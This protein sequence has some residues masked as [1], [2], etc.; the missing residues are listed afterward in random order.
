MGV[1]SRAR[2]HPLQHV[3][4]LRKNVDYNTTGIGTAATVKMSAPLPANAIILATYV[5]INTAFNAGT[6]NP[7]HVGISGNNT[8]L[9]NGG[10][11]G[12]GDADIDT[13][14]TGMNIVYRGGDLALQSSETEIYIY[15]NQ[16]GTAA[17]AGDADIIVAYIPANDA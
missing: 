5:K 4:Y 13:T 9:V 3:H 15:Y 11:T 17:T 16:S 14:A 8:A 12:A 7:I 10:T 1:G 6:N 2:E